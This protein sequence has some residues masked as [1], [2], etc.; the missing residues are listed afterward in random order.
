M[1]ESVS[2]PLTPPPRLVDKSNS[3]MESDEL[4]RR[5]ELCGPTQQQ[6]S[7]GRQSEK[8]EKVKSVLSSRLTNYVLTVW[9]AGSNR[10]DWERKRA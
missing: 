7:R 10:L 1:G 6:K 9:C 5:A 4:K 2:L 8:K 3:L